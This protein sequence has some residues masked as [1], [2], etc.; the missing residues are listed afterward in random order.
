MTK[1]KPCPFCGKRPSGKSR[2]STGYGPAVGCDHCGADGPSAHYPKE[3]IGMEMPADFKLAIKRWNE[4][5]G[6]K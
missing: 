4:R 5:A 1:L 6:S 3:Q 2:V